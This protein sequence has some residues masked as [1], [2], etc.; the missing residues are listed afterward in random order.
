MKARLTPI[1][2]PVTLGT[3]PVIFTMQLTNKPYPLWTIALPN[4]PGRGYKNIFLLA[5]KAYHSKNGLP[6]RAT[7]LKNIAAYMIDGKKTYRE[8][9]QLL[10]LEALYLA[11]PSLRPENQIKKNKKKEGAK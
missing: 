4:V 11:K 9:A 3:K 5:P 1:D 8:I 10:Q 6:K 2:S 7:I